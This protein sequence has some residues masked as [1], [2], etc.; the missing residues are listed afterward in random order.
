MKSL[1]TIV[2]SV[3][4]LSMPLL[5]TANSET[6][7]NASVIA[8]NYTCTITSYSGGISAIKENNNNKVN[9]IKSWIPDSFTLTDSAIS[10]GGGASLALERPPKNGV[11]YAR[12]T[13]KDSKGNTMRIRYR[14]NVDTKSN[15][16]ISMTAAG[17]KT[18]G[19]LR[20]KCQAMG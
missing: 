9:V 3:A 19:P 5:A 18:L 10:F 2:I 8:Q 14:A 1:L 4:A 17:Y 20:I 6:V 11:Y 12:K 7:K 16:F 13:V 15:G